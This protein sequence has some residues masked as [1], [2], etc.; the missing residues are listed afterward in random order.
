MNA[1]CDAVFMPKLDDSLP[2]HS[3][4]S[5]RSHC[6]PA[7]T[8]LFLRFLMRFPLVALWTGNTA[9]VPVTIS[10]FFP[11]GYGELFVGSTPCTSPSDTG[12]APYLDIS[13]QLN[14]TAAGLFEV[15]FQHIVANQ[16]AVEGRGSPPPLLL[17]ATKVAEYNALLVRG[18]VAI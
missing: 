18:G 2:S 3:L 13:C 17:Y 12:V 1:R 15:W 9:L 11:N 7:S 5:L 8:P 14:T 10:G 4:P 16:D 6:N